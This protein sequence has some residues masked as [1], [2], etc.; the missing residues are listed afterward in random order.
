MTPFQGVLQRVCRLRTPWL[1]APLQRMGFKNVQPYSYAGW[2]G[3][4][5]LDK[6]KRG[7]KGKGRERR[8]KPPPP[9]T[10]AELQ[11]RHE[12]THATDRPYPNCASPAPS[13]P[14]YVH[15]GHVVGFT[16]LPKAN[17]TDTDHPAAHFRHRHAATR[18]S[19]PRTGL[20]AHP[21]PRPRKTDHVVV[22]PG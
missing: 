21:A 14:P 6:R 3:G 15:R 5:S 18:P 4:F 16:A 9:C 13:G 10:P 22:A 2:G 11:T 7:K 8:E 1:H 19:T 17:S 12:T 20:A